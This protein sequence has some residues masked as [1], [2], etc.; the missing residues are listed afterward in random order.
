MLRLDQYGFDKK[1]VSTRYTKLVLLH[2]MRSTSR[3]VHSGGTGWQNVE[4]LFFMLGWNR[5]EFH[6]K[7][8][9]TRYAELVFLHP[10]G[11]AGHV[12]HSSASG[13]RNVIALFF[14]LGGT[15][16]DLTKRAPRY[17]TPNLCFC[18]QWDLW[19]T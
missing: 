2:P 10:V 5:Y 1:H 9:G 4:A 6:K 7:C 19:V 17:V 3:V 16:T 14:M 8:T 13:L 12:V 18:I 15:G 11:Y